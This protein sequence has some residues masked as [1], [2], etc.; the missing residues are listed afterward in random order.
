M[1]VVGSLIAT[2]IVFSVHASNEAVS[3]SADLTL[4]ADFSDGLNRTSSLVDEEASRAF[5]LLASA[6]EATSF[7]GAQ[8]V[9]TVSAAVEEVNGTLDRLETVNLPPDSDSRVE[10][11]RTSFDDYVAAIDDFLAAPNPE[12]AVLMYHS[13]VQPQEAMVRRHLAEVRRDV[14]T[15]SL[16]E[17][18]RS[19]RTGT[20]AMVL[21]PVLIVILGLAAV[22]AL[23][24]SER[25]RRRRVESLEDL[26]RA[27][28]RFIAGV[29]HELRN[30]LTAVVGF[31]SELDHA[32]DEH[33]P[34]DARHMVSVI[35]Q[36]SRDMSNIVEDLLVATRS[37]ASEVAVYPKQ[38]NLSEELEGVLNG[39]EHCEFEPPPRPVF[40]IADPTRLRQIVRNLCLNAG[41][42]GGARLRLTPG[43]ENGQ[44]RLDIADDGHGI[45]DELIDRLFEPFA[46]GD[47][48]SSQPASTGLGLAVSKNLAQ[49][50][51]GDLV[52]RRTGNW[53]V[54][55][56]LL[57]LAR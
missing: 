24:N 34:V 22:G 55:S 11:L 19:S 45:P 30:P 37:S 53:S 8:R 47:H 7:G 56:L 18:A 35:H 14:S 6:P 57:P 42:H 50:M 32:W 40:V 49:L 15:L 9:P 17:V 39:F 28:D 31:A 43:F 48:G 3:A 44:L 51:G 13:R 25:D 20:V 29:S 41:R 21:G 46:H 4:I 52:Y 5:Y 23:L 38:L 2:V 16:E 33:D 10:H 54:F 36:Q 27:K 1:L 12:A 26:A